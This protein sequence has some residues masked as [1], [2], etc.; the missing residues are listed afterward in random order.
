MLGQ[1][2]TPKNLLFQES[3]FIY[4]VSV[5]EPLLHVYFVEIQQETEHLH[6]ILVAQIGQ[7]DGWM[8]E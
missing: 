2:L 3:L 6:D 5:L 7:M 8:N 4:S 1:V